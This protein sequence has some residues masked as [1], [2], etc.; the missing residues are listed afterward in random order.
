MYSRFTF[1]NESESASGTYGFTRDVLVLQN[2]AA[3]KLW[4][5]KSSVLLWKNKVK[6]QNIFH[7][8]EVTDTV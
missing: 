4:K 8:A 5:T 6:K 7:I 2:E 3:K 1:L